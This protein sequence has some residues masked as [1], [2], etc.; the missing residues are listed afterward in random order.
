MALWRLKR[1]AR[2]ASLLVLLFS[3]AA[4]GGAAQAAD[5]L[6]EVAKLSVD[7]TAADA[8]AARATGMG[9]AQMRAVKIVLQRLVPLSAQE[10]LPELSQEDV[11][12]MVNGVSIRKEE[13]STTRY[14]ATLDVSVSE[15]A[16]KQLLQDQGIPYGEER[17]PSISIL[18][19][20]IAGGSVKGEGGDV[21][22]QAW[23][24]LDLSHS[25]TPATLLRP[26]P[27]LSLET[28]KSVL[29]GDAQA[30]ASMQGD[31]GY[32]PL[33]IAVGETADGT[34]VTRLAGAD[35]VGSINFGRSDKLGG[36]ARAAA[37]EGAA[38]AFAIIEN[39]W[40][41]TQ[42]GDA[43]ATEVK[44]Q[45]GTEGAPGAGETSPRKGE[46]PRNVVAQ[47]EFSGLKDWQDIRGRLMNVAGIQALEVNSLSARAASIT[48][49]YA[50][51]L[52]RLQTE[53]G[54]NGFLFDERDGTFVLR[55]R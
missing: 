10:Q 14:I 8:V 46:V 15:R 3:F 53:L 27:D 55:S 16:I 30:L 41:V 39:R 49:D 9:E 24:D 29:A 33:V 1:S 35:S 31:Y 12:G 50:G 23:E 25:M 17:A 48:F 54:Q 36:D 26:R 47:V 19:L 34:F 43:P 13:N 11:E 6:Y 28:V 22:R 18:P 4:F 45:E 52:G 38:T 20:V 32:G 40:K 37:R 51:P 2:A 44:Y 7:T 21:W 5:S 42:S